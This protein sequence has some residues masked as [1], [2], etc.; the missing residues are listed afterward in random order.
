MR[1][2]VSD[3]IAW[4][5]P[6]WACMLCWSLIP[7][8]LIPVL[9]ISSIPIRLTDLLLILLALYYYV[10]YLYRSFVLSLSCP[11]GTCAR[12][13]QYASLLLMA[14]AFISLLWSPMTPEDSLPMVYTLVCTLSAFVLSF[15]L[16]SNRTPNAV[17]RFLNR[18][19]IYLGCICIIY[20]VESFFG[21]GLRSQ[22]GV[23]IY[24]FGIQRL[25]GPLFASSTG[26]FILIPCLALCIHMS[27][28]K[29][30]QV[31][32]VFSS[33]I[34]L[35]AILALGSRAALICLGTLV[36]TLF[37]TPKGLK[38]RLASIGLMSALVPVCAILV[39]SRAS[40]ERLTSLEDSARSETYD[41]SWRIVESSWPWC[42]R[43]SGYGAIW[44]W[45]QADMADGGVG[46]LTTGLGNVSTS[47]GQTLYHP[48]ST[49]LLL[50]IELGMAGLV[51]FITIFYT[52]FVIAGRARRRGSF[53]VFAAGL[54]ASSPCLFMDLYLFKEWGI[55]A[56]WLLYM[57]GALKLL[58]A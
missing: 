57:V 16:L 30:N 26:H 44:P 52:L 55:S 13:F 41:V 3:Q 38:R 35:I 49:F 25:K 54:I 2:L 20:F 40:T 19:S 34:F 58:D 12:T 15:S 45:Y 11:S 9:A 23:E 18:L 48:H 27:S 28:H 22:E 10:H 31:F 42:L 33:A 29:N 5:L 43:G 39:F 50:S 17:L 32:W 36:T 6:F 24:D 7:G 14:Y 4:E 46:V 47:F 51:F 1:H 56:I 8:T 21:L 53:E 37:L